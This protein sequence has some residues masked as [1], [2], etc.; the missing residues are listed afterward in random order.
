M[1]NKLIN[2][3]KENKNLQVLV[4]KSKNQKM[5]IIKDGNPFLFYPYL[6][7]PF[8]VRFTE[9]E[10]LL[11]TNPNFSKDDKGLYKCEKIDKLSKEYFIDLICSFAEKEQNNGLI[12]YVR[13]PF[14]G[15]PKYFEF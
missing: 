10:E 2:F 14:A 7:N 5:E 4:I 13:E 3:L 1:K 12:I 9:S 15:V 11:I 8:S 6:D